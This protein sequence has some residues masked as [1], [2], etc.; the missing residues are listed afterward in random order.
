[1][2]PRGS[3][4][5]RRAPTP[6]PLARAQGF[7]VLGPL[8]APARSRS[9]TECS[10]TAAVIFRF[11]YYIYTIVDV[12]ALPEIP[13]N[14]VCAGDRCSRDA[15]LAQHMHLMDLGRHRIDRCPYCKEKTQ[16][17]KVKKKGK[18]KEKN[19]KKKKG[20]TKKAMPE[21]MKKTLAVTR[22]AKHTLASKDFTFA[23]QAHCYDAC[24]TTTMENDLVS[25][26]T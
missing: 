25:E 19:V 21:K 10:V 9:A 20:K 7:R 11:K 13:A 3:A 14:V 15:D 12:S 26:H 23:S 22:V 6:P 4:T 5:D 8:R 24:S 1:M 17:K 18:K 16:E 2:P